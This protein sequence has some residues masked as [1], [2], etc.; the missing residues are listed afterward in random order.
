MVLVYSWLVH[1]AKSRGQL[2]GG[3][4]DELGRP[5]P[6]LCWRTRHASGTRDS[7]AVVDTPARPAR[8]RLGSCPCLVGWIDTRRKRYR[9]AHLQP[10]RVVGVVESMSQ[11]HRLRLGTRDR[12]MNY[13]SS[14][15]VL[16]MAFTNSLLAY[17]VPSHGRRA[18]KRYGEPLASNEKGE[19]VPV[20][21]SSPGFVAHAHCSSA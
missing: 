14:R 1:G 8:C 11:N 20:S 19:S 10:H 12:Q 15:A 2:K 17:P 4:P 18:L 5:L 21:A 7:V 6:L 16:S 9:G 13:E 3:E